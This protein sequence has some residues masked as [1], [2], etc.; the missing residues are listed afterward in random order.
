[1]TETNA[2]EVSWVPL[3]SGGVLKVTIPDSTV[4]FLN[5]VTDYILSDE[6][7]LTSLNMEDRLAGQLKNG[8]Q[9]AIPLT[10]DTKKNTAIANFLTFSNNL[11]LEYLKT[12]SEIIPRADKWGDSPGVEIYDLWVNQQLQG[13]YNPMHSHAQAGPCLSSVLYLKVPQQINDTTEDGS[14]RFFW[15][16]RGNTNMLEYPQILS[17]VPKP[18]DYYVFPSWVLHEVLPFRDEGERRSLSWNARVWV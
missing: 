15:G 13:D 9:R 7:D 16:D 8:K 1:M 6:D 4:N 10:D 17:I 14:L 2:L 12:Y 3:I 5:Q 11:C 18:G